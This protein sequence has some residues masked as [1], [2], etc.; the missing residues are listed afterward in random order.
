MAAPAPATTTIAPTLRSLRRR[1]RAWRLQVE[2]LM[3]SVRDLEPAEQTIEN[4][5]DRVR[6]FNDL[7]NGMWMLE[8]SEDWFG[9]ERKER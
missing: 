4:I 3:E 5:A 7:A 8:C 9:K 1:V 6:H 2:G